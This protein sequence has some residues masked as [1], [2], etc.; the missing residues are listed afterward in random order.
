MHRSMHIRLRTYVGLVA[1]GLSSAANVHAGSTL[2]APAA[3]AARAAPAIGRLNE[4]LAVLN[5][6]D[7]AAIARYIEANGVDPTR[8]PPGPMGTRPLPLIGRAQDLHRRSHGFD[9]VRL[10]SADE[11]GAVAIVRNRLTGDEQAFA[12]KVEPQHPHRILGLPNLP[13]SSGPA[14][15]R[16]PLPDQP[17]SSRFTSIG[18][19]LTRLADADVF[20]GVV[21]IARDGK[22]VFAQAYGYADRGRKIENTIDTPFMLA[23]MN[24]LFTGLAIGLLVEQGRLS[25]EDPLAKFMP[26]YPDAEGAKRIKVK[27]LL[28]HTAGL[29]NGFG[30]AF[31]SSLDRLR[32][33]Q[34]FIDV[35]AREP[36]KFEPGT[37][38]EYSNLSYQLLGRIVEIVTG[39][40][41]YDHLQSKVLGTAGI[42]RN[43][44]PHYDRDEVAF[45]RPYEVEFADGRLRHID[46]TMSH[47]RRGSPAGMGLGS[48]LDIIKFANA[49]EAGRI[50][51]PDTLRLHASP[52]PELSSPA[53]GYGFAT[54][55]RMTNRPLVGHGGN[56]GGIC[57]EFGRLADTPYTIVILSNSTMS[58]C[59]TV[60]GKIL[61]VLAPSRS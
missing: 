7:H 57:T 34:A 39:E 27:H 59:V 28:T 50:V 21:V 52:K 24:K 45:A 31:A 14:L 32:S 56:A 22:P 38:W 20:S 16:E 1:L 37:K 35:A 29:N 55:S 44:F 47:V 26:D 17:E 25:Y 54:V 33:V 23:S 6:G 43:W 18:A 15:A 30:P 49:L 61:Q 4:L 8:S 51:K 36:V 11:G 10:V 42:T 41:Y 2:A 60:T 53:Y 5:S 9:L 12:I 3:V 46:K 13:S 58:T 48:A 40:D 19:Y